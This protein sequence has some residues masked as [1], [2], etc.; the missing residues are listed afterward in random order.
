M[1]AVDPDCKNTDWADRLILDITAAD[2][3]EATWRAAMTPDDVEA[4][5]ERA[6]QLIEVDTTPPFMASLDG[7]PVAPAAQETEISPTLP[8]PAAQGDQQT[9]SS[10]SE[11]VGDTPQFILHSAPVA[12]VVSSPFV[13]A[14][15]ET[16]TMVTSLETLQ[17]MPPVTRPPPQGARRHRELFRAL[18]SPAEFADFRSIRANA[19]FEP[20]VDD[21]E[22]PEGCTLPHDTAAPEQTARQRWAAMN[23]PFKNGM[24]Y[25]DAYT[26]LG[27][28]LIKKGLAFWRM[29]DIMENTLRG[30]EFALPLF[31]CIGFLPGRDKMDQADPLRGLKRRVNA[32]R[33]AVHPDKLA[34]VTE[35]LDEQTIEVVYKAAH[36]IMTLL[37]D[38]AHAA[39]THFDRAK[40]T[41]RREVH[42]HGVLLKWQ[43]VEPSFGWWLLDT[44]HLDFLVLHTSDVRWYSPGTYIYNEES[45]RLHD[46]MAFPVEQAQNW[47]V[48][49]LRTDCLLAL[50]NLLWQAYSYSHDVNPGTPIPD[51]I[52]CLNGFRIYI[53]LCNRL[54]DRHWKVRLESALARMRPRCSPSIIIGWCTDA[55]PCSWHTHRFFVDHAVNDSVLDKFAHQVLHFSPAV[56]TTTTTGATN[57]TFLR[58]HSAVEFS[59]VMRADDTRPRRL[60]FH[61]STGLPSFAG[62][63]LLYVDVARQAVRN[64]LDCLNLAAP[65]LDTPG[66]V[67]MTPIRSVATSPLYKRVTLLIE[68]PIEPPD[69]WGVIET[70]WTVLYKAVNWDVNQI[71]IGPPALYT[72]FATETLY[73]VSA[74]DLYYTTDKELWALLAG[75]VPINANKVIWKL[76]R[77]ATQDDL[78]FAVLNFNEN[79]S[80]NHSIQS[81]KVYSYEDDGLVTI[82]SLGQSERQSMEPRI[83]LALDSEWHDVHMQ[84]KEY[85]HT[86][87]MQLAQNVFGEIMKNLQAAGWPGTE[88]ATLHRPER[89]PHGGMHRE[90]LRASFPS[91]TLA[92]TFYFV[93]KEIR[94][95]SSHRTYTLDLWNSSFNVE[96]SSQDRQKRMSLFRAKAK[97]Q[98]FTPT[99]ARLVFTEEGCSEM[100]ALLSQPTRP[101]SLTGQAASSSNAPMPNT[102]L[103]YAMDEDDPT[104]Y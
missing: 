1:C 9:L 49:F 21:S 26:I 72:R 5:I 104:Q 70:L 92:R 28:M 65:R 82:W 20:A 81:I 18:Y 96:L 95:E 90:W 80:K 83:E 89:E 4:L 34:T 42:Y 53:G 30:T 93:A 68:F 100:L 76:D 51:D 74:S 75:G 56:P 94:V 87:Y 45:T 77:S 10:V 46:K 31:E 16:T 98:D 44:L 13:E 67:N 91:A 7:P 22:L 32:F 50:E 43:E 35:H 15:M 33:L 19:R 88:Y 73:L 8:M 11:E 84:I 12:D 69:V 41:L 79:N 85:V 39:T 103:A 25:N 97:I 61:H 55:L 27:D 3:D 38:L 24:D 37:N 23:S 63:Y 52:S 57:M 2:D 58:V 62:V 99:V 59:P 54:T 48:Q 29:R 40:E 102:A 17:N 6:K 101:P 71:V 78:I 64:T 60:Y 14:P 66:R 47:M 86:D 36:D